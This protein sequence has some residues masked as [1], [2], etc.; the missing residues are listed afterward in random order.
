ML[1]TIE[2]E[3]GCNDCIKMAL[4]TKLTPLFILFVFLSAS[5]KSGCLGKLSL[6]SLLSRQVQTVFFL[7]NYCHCE[8]SNSSPLCPHVDPHHPP[9][10]KKEQNYRHSACHNYYSYCMFGVKKYIYFF[11]VTFYF[12]S[13]V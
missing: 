10:S 3:S 11:I 2:L 13:G 4:P 12:A 9:L 7:Q 6:P 1:F 5:V 8:I